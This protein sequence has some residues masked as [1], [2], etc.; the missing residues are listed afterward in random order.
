MLTSP[1][2]NH[3]LPRAWVPTAFPGSPTCASGED[4]TRRNVGEATSDLS[5]CL[6]HILRFPFGFAWDW[7]VGSLQKVIHRR[8]CF[9]DWFINTHRHLHS[10]LSA[11]II[12]G[13]HLVFFFFPDV[14]IP[15]I[16][17]K[18]GRKIGKYSAIGKTSLKR[19]S[20]LTMRS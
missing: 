15:R 16:I 5:I 11:K 3:H 2:L 14:F 1:L 13:K 12:L 18:C 7:R 20:E 10:S 9:A 17:K 6:C 4:A 19:N 8:F